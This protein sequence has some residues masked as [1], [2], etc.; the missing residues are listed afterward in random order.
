MGTLT[1]QSDF[2]LLVVAIGGL[3]ATFVAILR[4]TRDRWRSLGSTLSQ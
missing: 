2:A 1:L 3:F 4:D